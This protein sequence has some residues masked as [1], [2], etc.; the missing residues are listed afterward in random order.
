MP[1]STD[2]LPALA[3]ARLASGL[4]RDDMA[5]ALGLEKSQYA[6]LEVTPLNMSIGELRALSSELNGDGKAILTQWIC[7]LL[8]LKEPF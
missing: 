8:G 3:R 5:S 7:S 2:D 1:M 4:T 6:S